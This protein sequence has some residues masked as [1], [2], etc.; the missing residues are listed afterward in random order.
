MEV[1]KEAEFQNLF[2]LTPEPVLFLLENMLSG[3]H[4]GAPL[5]VSLLFLGL[6][7]PR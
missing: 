2:T 7:G 6:C 3:P 1:T 4:L 5:L